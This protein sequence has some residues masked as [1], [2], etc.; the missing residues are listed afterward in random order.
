MIVE[1]F[2]YNEVEPLQIHN[3]VTEAIDSIR[4][5][6]TDCLPVF[7]S[8]TLVNYVC[9]KNLKGKEGSELLSSLDSYSA[10]IPYIRSSRHIL[11]ALSYLK[12]VEMHSM[13]VLD[14]NNEFMGLVRTRD[15]VK[16][17]SQSLTI[18]SGG[19]I[20]VVKMKTRDYSLAD[21]TRIVEYSDA[22]LLGILTFDAETEGEIEVHLKLNTNTLKNVLATMERFDYQ[23]IQY[24]NREDRSED[25]NE[26]Y[27][28]LMNYIDL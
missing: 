28:N 19:A 6:D 10:V 16:A 26:R 14:D 1:K 15:L 3:T 21:L 13:A 18:R 27:E 5:C 11:N 8:G 24:F 22:K 7:K 20:I 9:S 17:L 23:V 4:K 25:L 12:S 2:V